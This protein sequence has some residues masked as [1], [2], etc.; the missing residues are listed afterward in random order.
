MLA[1]YNKNDWLLIMGDI[2][3]QKRIVVFAGTRPEMIKVAPVV[4]LLRNIKSLKTYFVHTGQHD[5]LAD[6]VLK[7][8]SIN[9]DIRFDLKRSNN[10]LSELT[11][12]LLEKMDTLYREIQPDFVFAQGDTTSVFCAGLTC[13]YNRIHF[14]H[15]EAGLRTDDISSPFPEEF[16]RRVV[17][18]FSNLNFCPTEAAKKNL[19][20]SGIS[21]SRI[22]VTGN[23]VID[24][25][26]HI[27]ETTADSGTLIN[28]DAFNIL[29]TSHRRE[30]FGEKQA[31]ILKALVELCKMFPQLNI[32]FP[33]H[34]NPEVKKCVEQHLSSIPN[35]KLV[36]PLNYKELVQVLK[37]CQLA[38]TDSG[39]IQE[40]APFLGIPVV[41]VR[42]ETER[43]EVIEAGLGVLVGTDKMRIVNEI[44]KFISDQNYRKQFIKFKSPY[45]DGN[46]S[47]RIVD[48][49]TQFLSREK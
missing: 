2:L 13:F 32:I 16:N 15:I 9:V 33:V 34:P 25:L 11:A 35:V 41:V 23:T 17:S 39:G 14:G 30:N 47:Q 42:E 21:E 20:L 1:R 10:T 18:F 31:N 24:S 22:Y 4:R 36:P 3:E 28:K 29:F 26:K 27:A 48:I 49:T 7:D 5:S 37:S 12:L 45:G 40:E 44:S 46:A 8:F 38:V 19:L 6:Q 43:Q